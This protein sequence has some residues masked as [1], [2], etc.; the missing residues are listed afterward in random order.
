MF[1]NRNGQPPGERNTDG[2]PAGCT[3][4][5]FLGSKRREMTTPKQDREFIEAVIDKYLLEAAIEW[6]KE[7]LEPGD[8]FSFKALETWAKSNRYIFDE[9]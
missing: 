2:S 4:V 3:V 6:I 5:G 7:N 9:T 8:V 1:R